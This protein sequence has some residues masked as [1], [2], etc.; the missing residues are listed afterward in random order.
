M[1]GYCLTNPPEPDSMTRLLALLITLVLGS[2][3][4]AAPP[5]ADELTL[6]ML[7]SEAVYTIGGLK[8]ISDG[9]WQ[10]RFP[11]YKTTTPEIDT[12]RAILRDLPFG[13]EYDRGVYVFAKAFNGHKSASAFVLHRPRFRELL[14]RHPATFVGLGI[15]AETPGQTIMEKIDRAPTADRWRAFGLAFGYPDYAVDFFVRSGESEKADGKFIPR[16]FRAIPTVASDRGRFVYAVPKGHDDR[17]ED[18]Q[19]A[20]AAMPIFDRYLTLRNRHVAPGGAGPV[21]VL[22]DWVACS[23]DDCARSI[24]RLMRRG[25]SSWMMKCDRSPK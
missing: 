5:T 25:Q 16:D 10:Q 18:L 2:T 17:P 9:F 1:V 15:T 11:E 12:V 8:P 4:T 13:P 24:A 3:A 22:R 23:H 19:L 21:A 7:D 14:R 6:A 20:L